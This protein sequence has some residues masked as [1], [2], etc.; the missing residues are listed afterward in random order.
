LLCWELGGGMAHLMNLRPLAAGLARRGHEVVAALRDLSP[1]RRV[2]GGS[3]A[4]FLQAPFRHGRPP[5]IEP[6]CSF[7]H[8]LH[9]TGFGELDELRALAGAWRQL[10]QFVAP[11]LIVFEHSPTAL[12]AARGLSTKRALLGGGFFCPPDTVRLPNLR[13]WIRTDPARLRAD[14]EK[15]LENVNTVLG[16]WGEPALERIAS[17]YYPVDE[18]FL[19]GFRELDC[20][21]DR[22]TCRYWGVL[23]AGTG[24]PPI[25]PP[26]TGRRVYAYL[27]PFASL[28]QLLTTMCSLPNPILLVADG[29]DRKL[30][31]Q[32]QRPNLCYID[33]LLE[34]KQVAREC[35][36]AILNG[37]F[38]TTIEMLL[39]GKPVLQIPIFL[40][41]G[42][43][44]RATQRIGAGLCCEAGN[45]TEVGNSLRTMLSQD[46]FTQGARTFAARHADFDAA[47]QVQQIIE[48][49][50]ALA[51][52]SPTS[53]LP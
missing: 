31:A 36:L 9:N 51:T 25:W 34:I 14:E 30:R 20:Y 37:N 50:D 23:P 35:D 21:P 45:A 52:S 29:I 11:D 33:G 8:L 19:L 24:K 17:L 5:E 42:M 16:E 44:A 26:G 1:A 47:G 39:A 28:P 53:P 38:G 4:T 18:N 13:T 6:A 22:G 2:F 49:L 32:F 3:E 12:L 27:K 48:R 41:Q 43:N 40:E 15:V 10:L 7:A 46:R